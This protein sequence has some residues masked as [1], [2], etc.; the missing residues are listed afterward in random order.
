MVMEGTAILTN[1]TIT[2]NL[3]VRTD[4]T[5]V[6]AG[7]FILTYGSFTGMNNIVYDNEALTDPEFSGTI[8]FTYSCSSMPLN[9]TGNIT[10]NPLFV[11]PAAD[12]FHLQFGSPCVDTG[13]PNSPLDPDGSRADMGA[14]YYNHLT[15]PA[16]LDVTLTPLNPPI[17]IPAHGGRFRFF[18]SVVNHGPAA[19]FWIWVRLKPPS[20]PPQTIVGPVSLNPPVNVTVSRSRTQTVPGSWSPGLYTITGYANLTVTYPAIDS[21]SFTFT[22]STTADDGPFVGDASCTGAPFPYEIGGTGSV[23]FEFAL[24]EASP[25][26][27]NPSTAIRYELRA[28]SPVNLKVYDTAGRSVATLVDGWREAGTH[29]VTFDGSNLA[30]GMYL[31]SLIAGEK[32]ATGKMLLV[33]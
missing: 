10:S 6:G 25:N 17:V 33:K 7:L 18:A 24:L 14:L 27:F 3:C 32:V 11:A 9:G 5:T 22:K 30:S 20:L 16:N 15:P 23:V 26:P 31:Y 4:T 1:N 12:N 8:N 19:P 28:A 29:E 13:N 2:Q 21:S